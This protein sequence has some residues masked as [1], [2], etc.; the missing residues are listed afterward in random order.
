[1]WQLLDRF[2]DSL[3]SSEAKLMPESL[4]QVTLDEQRVCGTQQD[5]EDE[6]LDWDELGAVIIETNDTGPWGKDFY[7][8]LVS[9]DNNIVACMVPAGATGEAELLQRLQEL[10]EFDN[11][12]LNA[13]I[14]STDNQHFFCWKAA[15]GK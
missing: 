9:R 15:S 12:A 11:E 6:S 10:P 13:A 1:M 8:L 5:G 2:F 14:C 4:Y 7:Y 3:L